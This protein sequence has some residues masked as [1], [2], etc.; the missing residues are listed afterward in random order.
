MSLSEDARQV[1]RME[2]LYRQVVREARRQGLLLQPF[3]HIVAIRLENGKPVTVVFR[4]YVLQKS[5]SGKWVLSPRGDS[6][7]LL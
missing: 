4:H 7:C 3:A 5:S 6:E 2:Q 1:K